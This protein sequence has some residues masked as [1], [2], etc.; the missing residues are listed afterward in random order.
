MKS[1][2]LPIS[3]DGLCPK[4]LTKLQHA[5]TGIAVNLTG[6]DKSYGGWKLTCEQCGFETEMILPIAG[7]LRPVFESEFDE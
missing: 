6:D 1:L 5:F 3:H 4:C 2:G 7:S